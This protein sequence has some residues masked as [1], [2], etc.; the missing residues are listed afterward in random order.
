MTNHNLVGHLTINGRDAYSTWGILIDSTSLS[1]LLT[2]AGT[3]DNV[4]ST[5]RLKHGTDVSFGNIK[6][7][8]RQVNLTLQLIARDEQQFFERYSSFC[9]ELEKGFLNISTSYQPGVVYKFEYNS[10]QQFT[11]FIREYAKFQLRLT[12]NDPSDRTFKYTPGEMT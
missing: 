11:Q 7:A 3:K 6:K 1:A 10:C 8:S 2:P 4:K 12:E 5:S 9:L